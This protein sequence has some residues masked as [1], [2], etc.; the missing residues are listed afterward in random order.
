M[1]FTYFANSLDLIA[2]VTAALN[3]LALEDEHLHI[4]VRLV[5]TDSGNEVGRWSDEIASDC[6]SYEETW[7]RDRKDH[8]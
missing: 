8:P 6:W 3:S 5:E 2:K 7:G 1:S 4:E